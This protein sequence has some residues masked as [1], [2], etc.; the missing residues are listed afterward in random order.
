MLKMGEKSDSYLKKMN[1]NFPV[2]NL[3]EKNFEE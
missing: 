1:K 3:G 2:Q